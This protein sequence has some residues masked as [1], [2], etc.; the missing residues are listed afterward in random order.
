VT[1]DGVLALASPTIALGFEQSGK[2]VTLNVTLG[3]TVKKGDVLAAVD[4]TDLQ[5]ALADAQMSL[6]QMEA[7]LKV[8][9]A[10]VSAQ[11]ITAAQASLSVAY[12]NYNTTKAGTT[13]S[14]LDSAKRNIDSAW[15]SYISTQVKRDNACG[16]PEGTASQQCKLQEASF[17]NAYESWASAVDNYNKLQE[18]VSQN[19]L[20]QA[21]ASI[22]SAKARLESLQAGET[23][24]Q[25]KIDDL[26]ISQ[27]KAAVETA[28][29]NLSKAT[30]VSPCD[31]VVQEIN[32][33]VG[34][35]APSAAFTLVNLKG[36]QFK[37]T[38]LTE[39]N[40]GSIKP[41]A[42]ATIRVKAYTEEFTG[43]V[44]AVLAESSGTTSETALYT[45]LID[46]DPTQ[47]M[48]LPG[49]TGQAEITIQ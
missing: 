45:V 12:I 22:V 47:Q 38:N 36:L 9:N 19:S 49:M 28:Q 17:G 48:L 41:G 37:T 16:G 10:P 29:Q 43:K 32:A 13:Q 3:Q 15:L 18:P 34:V 42:L 11:E 24:E 27:A 1:A 35:Q 4:D 8:Q 46:L 2:V 31:C 25:K 40:V 6:K 26:Q 5:D 33:A 23:A 30:L 39:R 7:N 21:Y 20:T 44:S 14:D